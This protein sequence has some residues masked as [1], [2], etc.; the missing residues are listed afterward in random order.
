MAPATLQDVLATQ[1]L[2]ARFHRRRD[3]EAENRAL[4][5][6]ARCLPTSPDDFLQ[7]AS[8][9]AIVLCRAHSTGVSL[10]EEE[11]GSPVFRWHAVSGRYA[12]NVWSTMPKDTSPCGAV[13]DSGAAQLMKQPAR[14]FAMLHDLGPEVVEA[15]LTPLQVR[16][17]PIGTFWLVSHESA[18]KFAPSDAA[19]L[20]TLADFI[21][22]VYEILCERTGMPDSR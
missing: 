21:A 5:E 18:L 11:Q 9:V 3:F 19:A 15:L 13:I 16:G 12:S 8:D 2:S 17:R 7:K 6:L 22:P 20:Q 14:C 10:L 4:I 1:E